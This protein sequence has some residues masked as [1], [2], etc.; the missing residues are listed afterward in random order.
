MYILIMVEFLTT[1]K[2]SARL[3]ELIKNAREKL[4]LVTPYIRTNPRIRE[5][6]G[7]KNRDKIPLYVVYGKSELSDDERGWLSS[8]DNLKLLFCENLHA[9]CYLNENEII[10]TSMNLYDFSQINNTEM[11]VYI[12][13]GSDGELYNAI[14][15]EVLRIVRVSKNA[16]LTAKFQVKESSATYPARQPAQFQ[17]NNNYKESSERPAAK[18]PV[19]ERDSTISVSD[20]LRNVIKTVGSS[21][22][23]EGFCIRCGKRIEADAKHP[24]C[25]DCYSSWAKFKDRNYSEKFCHFCG[26][27]ADTSLNKPVCPSCYRSHKQ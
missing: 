17:R 15:E 23:D 11:G 21:L 9:K 6:L 13:K 12:C 5:Y 1:T 19:K 25:S 7:D 14:N 2:V 10:L 20:V 4:Y 8:M 22:K 18:S 27:K 3:E 26:K 16:P 24:L